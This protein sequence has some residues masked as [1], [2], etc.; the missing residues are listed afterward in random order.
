MIDVKFRKN[1]IEGITFI[2]YSLFMFLVLF[3]FT[4][5][6]PNK[7]TVIM[8]LVLLFIHLMMYLFLVPTLEITNEGIIVYKNKNNKRLY[9]WS[10]VR[11]YEETFVRKINTIKFF[12]K[13][14]T[15]VYCDNRKK[16][17]EAIQKYSDNIPNITDIAKDGR[18]ERYNNYVNK[19]TD[20]SECEFELINSNTEHCV[21]CNVRTNKIN[22]NCYYVK[23]NSRLFH[24]CPKCFKDFQFYYRFKIKK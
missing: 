8:S 22:D 14:D 12:L 3:V 9:A 20:L 19:F 10:Q 18:A 15:T 4:L 24:I 16:I 5:I 1:L 11:C 21:F 13:D 7:V 2:A 23:K 6:F 17:K